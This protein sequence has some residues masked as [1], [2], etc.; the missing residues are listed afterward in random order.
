MLVE[1]Y[2]EIHIDL[3]QEVDDQSYG[4]PPVFETQE[5]C[6]EGI[7]AYDEGYF[8]DGGDNDPYGDPH[9]LFTDN[10][11][12]KGTRKRHKMDK[13]APCCGARYSINFWIL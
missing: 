9:W 12:D 11:V 2:P 8:S 6:G 10:T 3:A 1:K 5:E 7:D 4:E 13:K